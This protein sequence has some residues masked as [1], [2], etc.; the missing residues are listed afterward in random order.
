MS[1][2]A[3]YKKLL[4]ALNKAII[5]GKLVDVS[6]WN[7]VKGTNIKLIPHPKSV[8]STKKGIHTDILPIVSDNI[9]A[10]QSAMCILG[11]DYTIYV[12]T[13]IRHIDACINKTR[14]SHLPPELIQNIIMYLDPHSLVSFCTVVPITDIIFWQR[15]ICHDVPV[16][17]TVPNQ[18][19]KVS[20]NI[21]QYTQD[22]LNIYKSYIKTFKRE[23][24]LQAKYKNS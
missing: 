18:I 19:F 7:S 6:M 12:D 23:L 9:K 2:N 4:I 8:H 15:K 17:F 3:P 24:S 20:S 11:P 14:F 13:Y 10:Y 1:M 5:T 16:Y 22:G 21:D